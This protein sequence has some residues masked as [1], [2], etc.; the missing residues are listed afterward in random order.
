MGV[1]PVPGAPA[2]QYGAFGHDSPAGMLHVPLVRDDGTAT[3]FA[4]P[5]FLNDGEAIRQV[6]LAVIG[7]LEAWEAREGLGA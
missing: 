7:A 4:V 3:A 1:S 6:A 2:W 5:D